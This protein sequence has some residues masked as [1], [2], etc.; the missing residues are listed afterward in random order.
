MK[1]TRTE[2]EYQA[3]VTQLALAQS[4]LAA[5][6]AR[7]T[8]THLSAPR[9]RYACEFCGLESSKSTQAKWHGPKCKH[10]PAN[11]VQS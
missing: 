5:K 8:R 3:V 9:R 2:E 1:F 6:I 4:E 7:T 11:K 10:N